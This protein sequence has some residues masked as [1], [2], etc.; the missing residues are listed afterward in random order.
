[1]CRWQAGD[2]IIRNDDDYHNTQ[3]YIENN[4][5]KWD[6]NLNPFIGEQL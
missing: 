2:H 5:A 4:P 6:W 1:M 3:L